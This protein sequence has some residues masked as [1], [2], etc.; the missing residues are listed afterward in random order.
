MNALVVYAVALVFGL[1]MV[2]HR[3]MRWTWY[4]LTISAWVDCGAVMLAGA[5]LGGE[6]VALTA[7]GVYALSA[8]LLA[9]DMTALFKA[10]TVLLAAP[11]AV[12]LV[13]VGLF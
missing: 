10:L 8:I 9:L 12:T 3:E 7:G 6:R 4:A 5:A 11:V 1:W 2:A 13:C